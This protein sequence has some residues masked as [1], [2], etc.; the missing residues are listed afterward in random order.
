M[1]RN[2]SRVPGTN[3]TRA[4]KRSE[5][6]SI[7]SQGEAMVWRSGQRAVIRFGRKAC[8]SMAKR[9]AVHATPVVGIGERDIGQ[10]RLEPRE[11][12]SV[13]SEA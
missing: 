4:S 9:G 12:P 13:V 6:T 1:A 8:A 10:D 2:S 5:V 11:S 3:S 7:R